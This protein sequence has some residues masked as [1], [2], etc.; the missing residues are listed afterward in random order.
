MSVTID[1]H[2]D[3]AAARLKGLNQQ[4]ITDVSN[5]LL[6]DANYFCPKRNGFLQRSAIA[7]SEPALGL[8]VWGGGAEI[9]GGVK[10]ARMRYFVGTP[11]TQTNPHASLMW[12]HKAAKTYRVKYNSMFQS[13]FDGGG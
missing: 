3:A 12:A 4:G 8:L 10:Y 5:E 1:F 2:K 6:K 9:P 13:L 7:S 11:R